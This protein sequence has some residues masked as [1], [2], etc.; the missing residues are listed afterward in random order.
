MKI[1]SNEFNLNKPSSK[2]VWVPQHSD[3]AIGIKVMKDDVALSSS[4]ISAYD[5]STLLSAD[6][7]E[8]NGNKIYMMASY[9]PSVKNIDVKTPYGNLKLNVETT[10]T[11]VYDIDKTGETFNLQPATANTLG[12]IKVGANL[13]ISEDGTLSASGGGSSGASDSGCVYW[14]GES[15]L[16]VDKK[17]MIIMTDQIPEYTYQEETMDVGCKIPLASGNIF[18]KN[19]LILKDASGGYFTNDYRYGMLE[20]YRYF[21][22]DLYD[23]VNKFFWTF[24]NS[25]SERQT[26]RL[27]LEN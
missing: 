19:S 25:G 17:A 16:K 3:Y 27:T 9:N 11:T 6:E 4:E 14:D 18:G 23:Y 22:Y 24:Y 2:K 8:I 15:P 26:I 13:G 12:G 1:Y 10:D 20:I 7:H 5:G 21:N